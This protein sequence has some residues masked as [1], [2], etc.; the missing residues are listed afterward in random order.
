[1][2]DRLRVRVTNPATGDVRWPD[3]LLARYPDRIDLWGR[4][5]DWPDVTDHHQARPEFVKVATL[6]G[7]EF[8]LGRGGVGTLTVNEDGGTVEYAASMMR[9]CC[10]AWSANFAP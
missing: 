9:N 4:A 2:T 8:Q 3:V 5:V 7:A 1:M 6:P 10:S